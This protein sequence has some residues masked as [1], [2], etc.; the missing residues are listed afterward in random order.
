MALK[1][2]EQQLD[3]SLSRPHQY[4]NI[5]AGA[6]AIVPV[7]PP[8]NRSTRPALPQFLLPRAVSCDLPGNLNYFCSRLPVMPHEAVSYLTDATAVPGDVRSIPKNRNCVLKVY[9]CV[10]FLFPRTLRQ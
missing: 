10:L 6:S 2:L 5:S 7:R 3:P 8:P 4:A 9:L 1:I